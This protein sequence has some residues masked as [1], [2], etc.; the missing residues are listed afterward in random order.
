MPMI[1]ASGTDKQA[2]AKNK[3]PIII[4]IFAILILLSIPLDIINVMAMT[5]K[6]Y[7]EY[8][9]NDESLMKEGKLAYQGKTIYWEKQSD[10]QKRIII[11]RIAR[12]KK[13][14]SN[15]FLFRI[16]KGSFV[17]LSMILFYSLWNLKKWTCIVL[18]ANIFFG[19]LFAVMFEFFNSAELMLS[20]VLG[21]I[22]FILAVKF[23]G[24][25]FVH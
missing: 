4:T 7:E 14:L 1:F 3:R 22:L 16:F 13:I 6:T 2:V 11:D 19:I 21:I 20:L 25:H 18:I 12:N 15:F 23:Y 8:I 17:L 9:K 10:A 24:K 5:G